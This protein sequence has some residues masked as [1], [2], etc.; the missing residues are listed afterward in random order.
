MRQG[1]PAPAGSCAV[2]VGNLPRTEMTPES[3][4]RRDTLIATLKAA[5][6][7]PTDP[8]PTTPAPDPTPATP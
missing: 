2:P 1:D 4:A 7:D 5:A 6:P 3:R 8:T